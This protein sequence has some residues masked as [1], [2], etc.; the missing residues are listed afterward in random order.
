MALP[1]YK[2]LRTSPLSPIDP[3]LTRPELALAAL[4]AIMSMIAGMLILHLTSDPVSLTFGVWCTIHGAGL[5]LVLLLILAMELTFPSPSTR[6]SQTGASTRRHAPSL[7]DPLRR[8]A[9]R[10]SPR[11]D[12]LQLAD[13]ER[14]P[15]HPW[16][17]NRSPTIGH[18]YPAP[19]VHVTPTGLPSDWDRPDNT[20]PIAA[21]LASMRPGPVRV[22]P[23]GV[24]GR[25]ATRGTQTAMRNVRGPRAEER[26]PGGMSPMA[27]W[28]IL[29]EEERQKE[30]EREER[31]NRRW[32]Y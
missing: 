30:L 6:L 24:Q 25:T 18:P 11:Y 12:A 27:F 19:L 14:G 21:A 4:F 9:H 32:S 5:L 28:W 3:P 20:R 15:R 31:E 8:L 7:M 23:S 17:P 10:F 29:L 2:H 22:M 26:M 1:N 13:L 16:N